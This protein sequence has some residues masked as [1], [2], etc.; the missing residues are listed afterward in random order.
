MPDSSELLQE[1]HAVKCDCLRRRG[2]IPPDAGG[3]S[4]FRNSKTETLDHQPLVVIG[5]T[6]RIEQFAPCDVARTGRAAVV[7]TRMH[8]FQV[9]SEASDRG[10]DAFLLDVGVKRVEQNT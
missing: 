5:G 3:G 7:L 8:M 6:Q 10:R 9:R 1:L 2:E 4:D